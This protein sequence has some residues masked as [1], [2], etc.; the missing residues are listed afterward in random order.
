MLLRQRKKRKRKREQNDPKVFNAR[1]AF[2]LW[3][4]VEFYGVSG[5]FFTWY[6]IGL[7][8]NV[9][10]AQMGRR[11]TITYRGKVKLHGTNV[12]VTIQHNGNELYIQRLGNIRHHTHFHHVFSTALN[13]TP[14][15]L[16]PQYLPYQGG[17]PSWLCPVGTRKRSQGVLPLTLSAQ[18][19]LPLSHHLW[20]M[21]WQRYHPSCSVIPFRSTSIS[22]FEASIRSLLVWKGVLFLF[23]TL[24]KSNHPFQ[25]LVN[26]GIM[27]GA[28]ICK[29]SKRLFAV[30]AILY[31]KT[32]LVTSPD[33]LEE[34][35]DSGILGFL[36]A[37][38]DGD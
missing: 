36:L 2:P 35:L 12:A 19:W 4:Y 16:Q 3:C 10:T 37:G 11:E 6:D 1:S 21:V 15:K 18:G 31:D 27:K 14:F 8:H 30:F 5:T 24:A 26:E 34:I 17:R 20:R 25:L 9:R 23:P 7:F 29:L 28:A 13:S 33:K 38:V 32:K 22:I